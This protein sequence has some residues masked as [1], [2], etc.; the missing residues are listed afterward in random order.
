MQ[1]KG[2]WAGCSPPGLCCQLVSVK[3]PYIPCLTPCYTFY[4]YTW[5]EIGDI[6][7]YTGDICIYPLYTYTYPLSHT[8]LYFLFILIYPLYTYT[9]LLS[10]TMLYFLFIKHT[11]GDLNDI[12]AYTHY[13]LEE[14]KR[15]FRTSS[16]FHT[17]S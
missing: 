10:H 3:L 9:D 14:V 8:M 15:G 12:S 7:K 11:E 1:S 13:Y 2:L 16:N 5:C 17:L 4:L 6:Y